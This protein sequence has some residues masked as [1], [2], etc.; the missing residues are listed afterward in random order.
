MSVPFAHVAVPDRLEQWIR[1][2]VI[3][4]ECVAAQDMRENLKRNKARVDASLANRQMLFLRSTAESAAAGARKSALLTL[5]KVLDAAG[6]SGDGCDADA[7]VE[8]IAE[9]IDEY[10]DD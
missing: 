8:D 3:H 9:A 1:N 2:P 7:G 10:A 4:C 6:A 5:A